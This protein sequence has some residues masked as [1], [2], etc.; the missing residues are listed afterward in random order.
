MIV[1]W[2]DGSRSVD[3]GAIETNTENVMRMPVTKGAV[4]QTVA[5]LALAAV[6]TDTRCGLPGP[7]AEPHDRRALDGEEAI[8]GGSDELKAHLRA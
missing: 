5:F 8:G 6:L 1:L 7:A 4:A 3:L 2:Y